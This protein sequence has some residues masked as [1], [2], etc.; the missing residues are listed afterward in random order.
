M[1]RGGQA[2]GGG[3]RGGH[4]GGGNRGS[5]GHRRGGHGMPGHTRGGR[6]SGQS[7][8]PAAST[9]KTENHSAVNH[10]AGAAD[11]A[12]PALQAKDAETAADDG[13][14]TAEA[15]HD[16]ED[17][18]D[19]CFI[20]AEYV[21]LYSL[22][23]CDHRVCHICAMRLR[24]LWK[25]R[26]CTF[27]KGD[28]TRVIFTP[29][30]TKSYGAYTPDELPFVDEKLS[31]YFE[32][33]QDYEDTLSLL[34][35][36]CPNTKCEAMCSGWSD[37][38][39]HVKREHSRLLCELC[40]RH[41]KIFSHEHSLFTAASLQA[42]LSSEHRYCEFCHQHFYSD[43]ELW[44][45]MRDRHE[46]CHICK[47]RSEEERWN[48]YRDYDMLEQHFR[49]EH[50]LCP[51][52]DCLETKF[53]VFENQMELQVH[54][55]EAHGHTLSN[56]ER[57]D[58]LRVDTR[59]M[60]DDGGAG[61]G[62]SSSGRRPARGKKPANATQASVNINAN[63]PSTST[64]RRA[65][66]GRSLTTASGGGQDGSNEPSEDDR[67]W[68]T[69]LTVLN[70]SKIKLTSCKAALR[71]YSLSETNVH[72]LLKTLTNL[73]GDSAHSLDIGTTDLV[74]QSM[75]EMLKHTEKR[76]ELLAAWTAIKEEHAPFPSLPASQGP[77]SVRSL[78]SAASGNARV[79]NNV[80][81]AA[82]SAPSASASSSYRMP[83]RT[84][85][86]FPT[87]SSA[88]ASRVP[89]SAAHTRGVQRRV[90][91]AAG[92]TPWSGSGNAGSSGSGTRNSSV[93]SPVA[94]PPLGNGPVQRTPQSVHVSSMSKSKTPA[95]PANHFPSLPTSTA[96]AERQAQKR[97]LFS[98]P[99]VNP[100]VPQAP[101][102]R[103]GSGPSLSSS[104]AG[105]EAFP[106]LGD[107]RASLPDSNDALA[108][109][110]AGNGKQR[111]RKGV[112]LSS[113]GSMHRI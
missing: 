70:D 105:Q 109:S 37:L 34:R 57:R 4:R 44:V 69:V 77:H 24:A 1:T 8:A 12:Q 16:E 96:H 14:D 5:S 52:R 20:C 15:G 41:K 59:F 45:H 54:Q 113:V 97:E 104:P 63:T 79:W 107:V 47:A 92:S 60:Y 64:Q 32:N 49:K 56:R 7:A 61:G 73:T 55:V 27:C 35:F 22:P 74:V 43:D 72:D 50:Y 86:H 13:A 75:C 40:I 68:S 9:S 88:N 58:A 85:D 100:L 106:A 19:I 17:E 99:R 10:E 90:N 36:N 81:R 84:P 95:L 66:F 83:A 25:K 53:V 46:Q 102:T 23:P 11:E 6:A 82:S 111:R 62:S 80:A 110:T 89:G 108:S 78:K 2:R 91:T 94:F 76:S 33:R 30:D 42:H 39:G 38:K 29:N 103:W 87:L 65:Q 48:Y 18:R 67:Y 71:A 93:M 31:V 51:A 112:L 3:A 101:P 98:Q 26:E 21:Q 28:A